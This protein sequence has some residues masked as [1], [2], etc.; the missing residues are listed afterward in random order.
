MVAKHG[1]LSR[2]IAEALGGGD[3]LNVNALDSKATLIVYANY[4]FDGRVRRIGVRLYRK[5][6]EIKYCKRG[7]R[8]IN[9]R[10]DAEPTPEHHRLEQLLLLLA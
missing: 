2:K 3:E 8:Q 9:W 10:W 4:V 7:E 1:E 5:T 6:G